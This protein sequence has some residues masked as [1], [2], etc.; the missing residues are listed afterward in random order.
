MSGVH[1][2]VAAIDDRTGAT[3]S[4]PGEKRLS[5]DRVI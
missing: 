1:E 2:V 3:E 4:K 5:L